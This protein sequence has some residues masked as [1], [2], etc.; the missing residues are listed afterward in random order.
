MK[1]KQIVVIITILISVVALFGKEDTKKKKPD[2]TRSYDLVKKAVVKEFPRIQ[3]GLLQVAALYKS[4]KELS[5]QF[6]ISPNGSL[7]F[8]GFVEDVALDGDAEKTLKHALFCQVMDTVAKVKTVTKVSLLSKADRKEIVTLSP[9]IK[10]AYVEIRD[11][12]SILMMIDINRRD[13]AKA[14]SRRWKQNNAL[15]GRVTVKF[16]INDQ[17]DVVS[18]SVAEST[19]KDPEFEKTVVNIVKHWKFGPIDNPGDVTEVMYPFTF[20]Q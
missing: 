19:L 14:Y 1:M 20:T 13:L 16:G 7:S 9:K 2:P 12:E 17:G 3:K 10:V 15:S 5:L 6:Y 11:R 18:C 8:I 4:H